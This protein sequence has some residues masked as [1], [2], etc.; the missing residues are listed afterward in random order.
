MVRSPTYKYMIK[1]FYKEPS[2]SNTKWKSALTYCTIVN[3]GNVML[4]IHSM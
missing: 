4:Q 3:S 2:N 1:H